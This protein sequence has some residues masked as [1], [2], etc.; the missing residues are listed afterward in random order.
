MI[1]SERACSKLIG[2]TSDEIQRRGVTDF[3]AMVPLS[4]RSLKAFSYFMAITTTESAW[5][6]VVWERLV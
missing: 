6:R 5:T 4:P 1:P 2:P 3:L